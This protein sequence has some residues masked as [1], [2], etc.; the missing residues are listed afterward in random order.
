M[1]R[2]AML[3]LGCS[4]FCAASFFIGRATAPDAL[5]LPGPPEVCD[6]LDNDCDGNASGPPEEQGFA[7]DLSGSMAGIM[8][9][10]ARIAEAVADEVVEEA[11]GP[12]CPAVRER[13]I[14]VPILVAPEPV[15]E[16]PLAIPNGATAIEI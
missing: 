6:G 11:A 13:I 14:I 4:L 9:E 12:E 16:R 1:K 7:L 2:F 5:V 3:A 10:I 8:P 15:P